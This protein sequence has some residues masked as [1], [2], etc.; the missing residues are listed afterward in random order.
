[1]LW[2][3]DL[4]RMNVLV[5]AQTHELAGIVDWESVSI[6]PAGKREMESYTSYRA[7]KCSSRRAWKRLQ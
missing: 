7:M 5:D 2:H 1:M 4:S 3:D 6:L